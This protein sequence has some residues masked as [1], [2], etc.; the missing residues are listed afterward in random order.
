MHAATDGETYDIQYTGLVCAVAALGGLLFGYDFVVIGGAKPFYEVYFRLISAAQIGWANGCALLG[1]LAGSVLSGTVSDRLGRKNLLILSAV[2]F[3]VSSLLTAWANTF[4]MFVTWRI[5]GG[6][7]IGIASNVS[8]TYIA[9]ISPALW[10]GRLVSLNQITIVVGILLAQ[11]VNWIIADRVPNGAT[12]EMIRGSWNGQFGWRYMFLAVV[13]PSLLFFLAALFVPE[14]PRW[15]VL[16]GRK[17][18]AT[19]IFSRI[20][21][22]AYA[23]RAVRD[24]EV[25]TAVESNTQVARSQLR[26]PRIQRVLLIGVVLAILQQWSG[27]NILFNYAEEVYRSAGYGV[28]DI[29]FNIVITGTVNLVFTLIA[30]RIVDKRGRRP[31]ML[32]G[33]AGVALSH[34][35][36][37]LGYRL[38]IRGLPILLFTLLTIGCYAMSL[39]PVTW[40]L[41]SEIFPTRFRGA[42]VA[43]SVSA[44]WIAS[45]LL[46]FTFPVLIEKF[47][48]PGTF[49][50]YAF[51]CTAGFAFIY[52][53]VPE[54]K[55]KT[56]EEI[57]RELVSA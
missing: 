52:F 53:T 11:I 41:I 24:I 34:F 57:E 25:A 48:T 37:G 35:L 55:G 43:V 51:I 5:L 30:F 7:A 4:S 46:T 31:L 56:L 44:L 36:I 45:F 2:L 13:V 3:G 28:N 16:H 23:L 19:A 54:T 9:E 38:G 29:L 39:A 21:G 33:C 26:S 17:Q 27:I 6:V 22:A 12:A 14:S 40:V 42:G 50:T 49:W 15:L 32:F 18:E 1:C 47:G 20:G 10:R 8:P